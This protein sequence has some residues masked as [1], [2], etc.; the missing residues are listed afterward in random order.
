[1][2]KE[3]SS[4]QERRSGIEWDFILGFT[5]FLVLWLLVGHKL[6]LNLA[7]GVPGHVLQPGELP[8]TPHPLLAYGLFVLA[9]SIMFFMLGQSFHKGILV[10]SL[11]IISYLVL[12]VWSPPIMVSSGLEFSKPFFV[13][14]ATAVL[15]ASFI[16]FIIAN[17]INLPFKLPI[18]GGFILLGLLLMILGVK[19]MGDPFAVTSCENIPHPV[20]M[21]CINAD[22]TVTIPGNL[23][24]STDSFLYIIFRNALIFPHILAWLASYIIL[25]VLVIATMAIF[26]TKKQL[27]KSVMDGASI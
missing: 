5:A 2:V 19:Y 6:L 10:S 12:D 3:F 11:G 17:R 24:L 23:A 8:P 25:P 7:I 18:F 26:L 21:F 15:I 22:K 9:Y 1:M 20:Q 27:K 4:N 14:V 13:G 16:F